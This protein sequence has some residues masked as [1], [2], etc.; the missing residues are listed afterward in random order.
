MTTRTELLLE[1]ANC[2]KAIKAFRLGCRNLA[3]D[4]LEEAPGI[5][6]LQMQQDVCREKL[7][8]MRGEK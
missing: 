8:Q 1:I 3:P 7:K 2:T 6:W 5:P 4:G